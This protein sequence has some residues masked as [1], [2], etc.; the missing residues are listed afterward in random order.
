VV[1]GRILE[2]NMWISRVPEL[3]CI[4]DVGGVGGYKLRYGELVFEACVFKSAILYDTVRFMPAKGTKG[5]FKNMGHG[6]LG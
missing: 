2:G 5:G 6:R 3:R 1:L 4:D